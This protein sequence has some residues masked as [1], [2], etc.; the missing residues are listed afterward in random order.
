MAP[1]IEHYS[2]IRALRAIDRADIALLV[3]DA[4]EMVTSQ[5]TH[6]A[7]YIQQADKGIMLIVNKWDLVENKDI[8]EWNRHIRR[9]LKFVPYAPVLYTSAKLGQG[10]DEIMPQARQIY[11]E[12][13]KR[14]P[15][16]AVNDVIQKAI[17]VHNRPR[18]GG[19]QL[20]VFYATQA[21]T[22]PPTFILFANDARLIHFS[23]KRYLEN[24]LRQAFG[25]A[26]TPLRLIFKTRGEE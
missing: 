22:N 19:K 14:L 15:T 23:Y 24:R 17:A 16:A 3:L 1:G 25:F 2:V 18:S 20:K 8:T 12:R 11:Q 5:D 26:G 7:G 6:I 10:V 13:L 4:T 9:Q 21:E